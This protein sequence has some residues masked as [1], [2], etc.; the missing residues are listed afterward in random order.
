VI[1]GDNTRVF[2]RLLTHVPRL[3]RPLT[4]A[5]AG[6]CGAGF[7]LI[8]AGVKAVHGRALPFDMAIQSGA[9]QVHWLSAQLLDRPDADRGRW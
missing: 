6:A 3:F 4:F 5:L 1:G 7:L 2:V 9:V 8:L